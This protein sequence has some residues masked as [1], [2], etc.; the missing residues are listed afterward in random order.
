[1]RAQHNVTTSRGSPSHG[2][3]TTEYVVRTLGLPLVLIALVTAWAF[4]GP[5]SAMPNSPPQ[6]M[7]ILTV[8]TLG[9]A[10]FVRASR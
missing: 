8:L 2:W 9:T 1:M 7:L 4:W 5:G 6:A 3:T 10:L